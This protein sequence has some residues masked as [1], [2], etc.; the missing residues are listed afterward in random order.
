VSV[1][2]SYE[3]YFIAFWVTTLGAGALLALLAIDIAAPRLKEAGGLAGHLFN[4]LKRYPFR[5][6]MVIYSAFWS[7][8]VVLY[9]FL[10]L[11]A[12]APWFTYKLNVRD[13]VVTQEVDRGVR[14]LRAKFIVT[15][16]GARAFEGYVSVIARN[17]SVTPEVKGAWPTFLESR[18][19]RIFLEPR[20]EKVVVAYSLKF[21]AS[22]MQPTMPGF[23][24]EAWINL[25]KLNGGKYRSFKILDGS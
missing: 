25:Y 23:F 13:V 9:A 11:Q 24:N 3:L 21:E 19:R 7:V 18:R 4:P 2:F 10:I 17:A 12:K 15:N 14:Y 20:G 1:N 8:I 5:T 22:I 16:S 6:R